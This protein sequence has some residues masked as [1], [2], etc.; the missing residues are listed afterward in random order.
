MLSRMAL[1][2]QGP[3]SIPGSPSRREQHGF[4][5]GMPKVTLS[6]PPSTSVQKPNFRALAETLVVGDVVSEAPV[7]GALVAGAAVVG[8]VVV[9][10]AVVA[11][12]VVVVEASALVYILVDAH[13]TH[14]AYILV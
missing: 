13:I 12:E 7:V 14:G 2:R 10:V 6:K 9:V 5:G 4:V 11:A 1:Q 8:V 3:V